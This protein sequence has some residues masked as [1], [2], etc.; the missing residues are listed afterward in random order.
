M[1]FS[2]NLMR[3]RKQKGLSQEEFANEIDV[4]RQTVSKWE[5]GVSTPEMEKLIQMSNFFGVSVDDLLNSDDITSKTIKVEETNNSNN[6][7]TS[8]NTAEPNYNN[9]NIEPASNNESKKRKV[10]T[11][12]FIAVIICAIVTILAIL[13]ILLVRDIDEKENNKTSK[14]KANTI[15]NVVENKIEN[16]IQNN[17]S[18][19]IE[20]KVTP[21]NFN[22]DYHNGRT[23]GEYVEKDLS[24]IITC[25]KTDK[26]LPISV[27][28]DSKVTS[29]PDEIAEIKKGLVL[30][31][32]YEI[33]LD[34]DN[35]GYMNSY[36]IEKEPKTQNNNND[37]NQDA[38]SFN[39]YFNRG[40]WS[41]FHISFVLE[42]VITSNDEHPDKQIVVK[43]NDIETNDRNEIKKLKDSLGEFTNYDV[44]FEYD[45]EG[46]INKYI[47][48]DK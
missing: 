38:H 30:T 2:E 11:V 36:K 22:A 14:N 16:E 24:K 27:T 12:F 15:Q 10:L 31:D 39:I 33:T 37:N 47:I 25:N 48:L 44:E 17:V 35:E 41:G 34:Y 40:T 9:Y 29:N 21:S 19:T 28:Y 1:S 7:N 3:L 20:N 46:Y 8:D 45:S 23:K 43:Y 5:L 26:N 18:N 42:R 32:Y 6:I 4:S 13:I